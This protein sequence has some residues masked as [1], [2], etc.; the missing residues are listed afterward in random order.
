MDRIYCREQISV[1][2]D[3]PAIVKAYTKEVVRYKPDDI[4]TFSRDYFTN[5]A[6]G[7]IEVFLQRLEDQQFT[8]REALRKLKYGDL[9]KLKT[10][11]I[12]A[13]ER[14]GLQATELVQ[15]SQ[16]NSGDKEAAPVEKDGEAAEKDV[17]EVKEDETIDTEQ[18]GKELVQLDALEEE[19]A[20]IIGGGK[21]ELDKLWK[22]L[23]VNGNKL[24]SQ[25]EL[26][27]LLQEKYPMLNHKHALREAFNF[28]TG[29][30]GGG[31]GDAYIEKKEFVMLLHALLL[32]NKLWVLFEKTAGADA[33]LT[34]EEYGRAMELMGADDSNFEEDFKAMDISGDGT[35]SFEE[36]CV[37]F[38]TR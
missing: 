5:L 32:F 19:F 35:V 30:E 17:I 25:A 24:V 20:A 18:L 8:K 1:P 4:L 31:D 15:K 7:D 27:R 34:L 13:A 38:A 28:A 16:G 12:S 29:T 26:N 33:K 14:A 37:A 21:P 9:G 3:L 22:Q 11:D 6:N 23:D 2:D 36:V 10:K